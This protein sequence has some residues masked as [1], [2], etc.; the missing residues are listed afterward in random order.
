MAHTSSYLVGSFKRTKMKECWVPRFPHK[1]GFLG[2]DVIVDA[3]TICVI[4]LPA[5]LLQ[6]NKNRPQ[7]DTYD[8]T[9]VHIEPEQLAAMKGRMLEYWSI[10]K[11]HF[12]KILVFEA[13]FGQEIYEQDAALVEKRCGLVKIPRP[14]LGVVSVG[15]V[16]LMTY[17]QVEKQLGRYDLK[18]LQV[19]FVAPDAD[20][21]EASS[22]QPDPDSDV[23][24]P[25][26][27]TWEDS[28]HGSDPPEA[29]PGNNDMAVMTAQVEAIT[30]EGGE[31]RNAAGGSRKK[32]ADGAPNANATGA[33]GAL[34]RPLTSPVKAAP[35][36]KKKKRR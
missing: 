30:V 14:D 21:G 11:D 36:T 4:E 27:E 22:H 33:T 28:I 12:N 35:K 2:P 9:S 15:L 8:P 3:S 19:S 29:I 20:L 7:S 32:K 26:Y 34:K 5:N 6:E 23:D 18:C 24:L 31:Q 13:T 25:L 17:K 10:K 1:Q 16:P